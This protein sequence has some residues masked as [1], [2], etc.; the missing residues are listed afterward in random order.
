MDITLFIPT[1]NRP[2][3]IIRMLSY[4]QCTNFH[5]KIAIGDGSEAAIAKQI[6]DSLSRFDR[7]LEINYR[8]LPGC[9]P[10]ATVQI[11]AEEAKTAYGVAM[12]D[13]DFLVPSGMGRCIEFL[14]TNPDYVAAQG[15]IIAMGLHSINSQSIQYTSHCPQPIISGATAARRLIDHLTNYATTLFAVHRIEAWRTMF[16]NTGDI[17]DTSFGSE[18]LQSGLSVILGKTKQLDGLYLIRQDHEKRHPTTTWFEWITSEAWYPSYT[19]FRHYLAEAIVRQDGITLEEAKDIVSQAFSVYLT[20]W[21]S[22]SINN[23]TI[24]NSRWRSIAKQIPGARKIWNVLQSVLN[25]GFN[26]NKYYFDNMIKP[27]SPYYEDF[28]PIYKIVTQRKFI[29]YDK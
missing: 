19:A 13:D 5:G 8:Y 12:G 16:K 18:S 7:S 3:F 14:G 29:T 27:E 22:R 25:R 2:E 6:K 11:L 23:P 4:Y 24:P 1:R 21:I 15:V 20:Q 9:N 26:D 10:A 17:T 28:V